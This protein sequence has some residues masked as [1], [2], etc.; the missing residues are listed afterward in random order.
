MVEE[1]KGLGV[2]AYVYASDVSDR[3]TMSKVI[4][5][6]LQEHPRV[7]GV[8][9]SAAV[10]NDSVY[11]NM[12]HELW[13]GAVAPKIQGSWLLHELLPARHGLLRHAQVLSL[14]WWAIEAK[15]I[16]PR[17][18]LSKTNWHDTEETKVYLRLLLI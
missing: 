8:I 14:A 13:R 4:G 6:C 2:S 5:Q 9:Q 7:R 16:M 10:L 11:D 15:Q 1:L 3:Q 12:T 18:T 17:E